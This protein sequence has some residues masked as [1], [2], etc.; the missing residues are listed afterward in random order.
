MNE[1]ERS[2]GSGGA[3][4]AGAPLKEAVWGGHRAAHTPSLPSL[5]LNHDDIGPFHLCPFPVPARRRDWIC[6]SILQFG[7]FNFDFLEPGRDMHS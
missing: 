3:R 2:R 7:E 5:A 6:S 4:A 1:K